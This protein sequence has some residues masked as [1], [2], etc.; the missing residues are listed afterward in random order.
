LPHP[1][2]AALARLEAS[3]WPEIAG[4]WSQLTPSGFPIEF[5]VGSTDAALRWTAE[6]AGPEI[7]EKR[8]V[9]IGAA[10]LAGAGEVVPT[11]LIDALSAL[12]ERSPLRFGAWIGGREGPSQLKLY[13]ELPDADLRALPLPEELCGLPLPQGAS[14]RMVGIEPSSGK[15]E[16]YLRLPA[17]DHPLP[18]SLRMALPWVEEALGRTLP[19][20]MR[21]LAGRRLGMSVAL[22]GGEL[23]FALFASA[24][25]LFPARPDMLRHLVPTLRIEA[26]P[27]RTGLLTIGFDRAAE[28]LAFGVGVSPLRV[29]RRDGRRGA[30]LAEERS[31]SALRFG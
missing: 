4:T 31:A 22:R 19:D 15:V 6:V 2:E 10:T 13:A 28:N 9:A 3:A 11:A 5:T 17:L 30:A 21:R 18:F 12:H 29:R 20:G 7:D 25:T 16:L 24:R 27:L 26:G 14:A 8:R 23:D 1:L